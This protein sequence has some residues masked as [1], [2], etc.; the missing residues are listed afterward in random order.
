MVE[1]RVLGT[2]PP[3]AKC[4]RAEEEAKKVAERFLGQ[5]R[6]SKL[7][8]MSPEAMEY[9]LLVTPAV[10]VGGRVV[11]SGKIPSEKELEDAIRE[12]LEKGGA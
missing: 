12:S 4:K 3:C 9:G 8:A 5:V 6:V 10:V 2:V 11:A 1:I 7:D